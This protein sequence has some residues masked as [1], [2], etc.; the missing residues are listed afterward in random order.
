MFGFGMEYEG[1]AFWLPLVWSALLALAVAMYVVIDGFDLGVGILFTAARR[2]NW[3]DRMMLSVAPIWDGNET[4]LVLG[5]GGLFAVFSVAYAILLPALYLPI[6]LMLIALIF[7]GVA[8]EFRFKADRSQAIWDYAFHYGSLIATFAQGMVLGA[9][10]QGF[11]IEG[12]GFT[13]GTLDWLTPFSVMTGIGLVCGYGLLGA[14]WCV[15]KTSGEL[16]IWARRKSKQFLA[17]TI[18]SMALVSAWVP[19]LGLEIQWRWFSWPNLLYVAP[20]PVVTAFV[21]WRIF[22]TLDEGREATPFLLSIGLFLLGFLGLAISLF[23]FIV[24][25]RLTIWQAANAVSALQFALVG[26]AVVMPLTLA[27]T[28]YAY[29]VF[30]GKV[31]ED[32]QAGGYGH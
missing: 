31:A 22:R 13:G 1:A 7:R 24:P 26:Y 28:A 11:Q 20:V 18:L 2:G 3:R 17:A 30:R 5:G 15:M 23:P 21:C 19:F 32:I 12:R 29:W 10:V 9:F 6:I 8:F 27:Y 25:P 4:W 16:E 14:T